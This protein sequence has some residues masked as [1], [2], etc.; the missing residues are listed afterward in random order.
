[1]EER[2]ARVGLEEVELP[3]ENPEAFAQ[4]GFVTTQLDSLVSWARTGSLMW[5][6]FGL[7]CCAV[8]M[9]Q[10]SMPRYDLER[11]GFAPRATPPPLR[12]TTTG[13][14]R[15]RTAL[16]SRK[17]EKVVHVEPHTTSASALRASASERSTVAAGTVPLTLDAVGP[18]PVSR[19]HHHRE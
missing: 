18:A 11:Y 4:R 15:S 7:A 10:A 13:R 12:I 1:M 17:A 2:G 3:P 16:S 5:M 14:P 9:M 8:E 6:T 19:S